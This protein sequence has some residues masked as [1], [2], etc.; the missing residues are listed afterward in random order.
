MFNKNSC[1]I[2]GSNLIPSALCKICKESVKWT[3]DKCMK[4]VQAQRKLTLHK[5]PKVLIIC[6]KRF[7]KKIITINNVQ[8][9]QNQKIVSNV[10][11]PIS[12]NVSLYTN[13]TCDVGVYRLQGIV[14]HTGGLS[15]GHYFAYTKNANGK[16]YEYNDA[17]VREI[18]NI[19]TPNAYLLFYIS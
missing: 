9:V 5:L 7:S 17:S 6:L 12:L 14:N 3:C 1:R 10:D 16:W 13:S 11:C 2:C 4:N 8:A 19:I 15:G 18:Q